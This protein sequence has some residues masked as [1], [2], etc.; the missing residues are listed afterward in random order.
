MF[1]QLAESV[2]LYHLPLLATGI[3]IAFFAAVLI[4]V[5]QKERR[6]EYDRMATLPLDHDSQSE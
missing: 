2:T 5:S 3:F 1:Q 4:R 6:S